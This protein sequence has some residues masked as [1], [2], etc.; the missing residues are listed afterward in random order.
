MRKPK[1][2]IFDL[3][4]TILFLESVNAI[5][6][7]RKQLEFLDN[8]AD[9]TVEEFQSKIE[10]INNDV[11]RLQDETHI[12]VRIQETYRL[13]FETLGLS[14]SIDYSEMTRIFWN[15]AVKYRPNDGIYDVLDTLDKYGIKTGI[16]SNA[17]FTGDVLTEE[18]EK[19]NL[20]H[21]FSFLISTAD[22]GIRKPDKR[23]FD[24]AI[25]KI[26]LAPEDIWFVGDKVDYD[27]KGAINAGLFPVLYN[28]RNESMEID[29]EHLI[30]KG[31][32]EFRDEIESLYNG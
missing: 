20:A 30:V 10:E 22:Y 13:V 23:I 16:L 1:G 32:Y 26:G 17:S 12:Q 11:F 25:K 19:H 6:G 18:L 4:G 3:G 21:R 27:I 24:V 7:S 9:I 5:N 14:S 31:W 29:S 8:D 28:W 15:A 2:V